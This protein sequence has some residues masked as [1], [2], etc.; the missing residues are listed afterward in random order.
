[1]THEQQATEPSRR[2]RSAWRMIFRIALLFVLLVVG[3]IGLVIYLL[4]SE[5]EY[6]TQHRL[7]MASRSPEELRQLADDAHKRFATLTE[8]QFDAATQ[9]R[10]ASGEITLRQA[11]EQTIGT[12]RTITLTL[13]EINAWLRTE[14]PHQIRAAGQEWPKELSDPGLAVEGENLVVFCRAEVGHFSQIISI[15]FTLKFEDDQPA[16]VR[17]LQA[18]G[19]RLPVPRSLIAQVGGENPNDRINEFVR[20]FDGQTF[21]PILD[22]VFTDDLRQARVV[23]M[24][25]HH[26]RI[27]FRVRIERK[28]KK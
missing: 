4:R 19:G 7:M 14:L 10:I 6:V 28:G 1:M 13:N 16:T 9:Q 17:V 2:R 27:D 24:Q 26:D 21:D 23:D 20:A 18:R 25:V 8:F 12:E 22:F 3:A 11:L 5:P 15:V